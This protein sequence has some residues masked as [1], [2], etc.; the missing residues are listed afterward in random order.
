MTNDDNHLLLGIQDYSGLTISSL[1]YYTLT[2]VHFDKTWSGVIDVFENGSNEYTFLAVYMSS[3]DIE[4]SLVYYDE[5]DDELKQKLT[6]FSGLGLVTSIKAVSETDGYFIV[7]DSS[8][9]KLFTVVK[10]SMSSE[11]FPYV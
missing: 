7:Q 3:G 1:N 10:L 6:T 8:D 4:I 9:M 2:T 11:A 5:N